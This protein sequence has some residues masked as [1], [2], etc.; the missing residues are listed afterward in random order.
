MHHRAELLIA[1]ILCAIF[2]VGCGYREGVV[3]TDQRSYLCFKG[4]TENAVV[5]LDSLQPF[6]LKTK[7]DNSGSQDN[8]PFLYEIS[9]GSHR[10]VVMRNNSVVVD[11][12]IIVGSGMTKEIQV[13]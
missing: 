6:Q 13:P 1:A 7:K 2:L 4:A 3:Q 12:V 11:R 9:S 8:C 10:V 5:S